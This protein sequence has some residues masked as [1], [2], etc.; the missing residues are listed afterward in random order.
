[1]I[2]GEYPAST[3]DCFGYFYGRP[4]WSVGEP[5]NY[6]NQYRVRGSFEL[7]NVEI[8]KETVTKHLKAVSASTCE[9]WLLSNDRPSGTRHEASCRN[10]RSLRNIY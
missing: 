8:E 5:F 3:L 2:E 6:V 10:V 9:V 7:T 1:M 4:T